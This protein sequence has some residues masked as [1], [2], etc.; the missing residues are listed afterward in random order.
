MAERGV[1]NIINPNWN[2]YVYKYREN[3]IVKIKLLLQ[4]GVI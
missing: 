2:N 3:F 1:K 4:K